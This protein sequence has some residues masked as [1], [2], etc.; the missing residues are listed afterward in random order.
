MQLVSIGDNS[1]ITAG[2]QIV[3][4]DVTGRQRGQSVVGVAIGG[5]YSN[6]FHVT[7]ER[8]DRINPRLP[9]PGMCIRWE[10]AVSGI[11]EL[12]DRQADLVQI[13]GTLGPPSRDSR[14]LRGR[15]Q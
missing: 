12:R 7:N 2:Y 15:Q 11:T 6:R 4:Q 9:G 5:T 1:W 8:R 13:V 10:S 3:T 14:T